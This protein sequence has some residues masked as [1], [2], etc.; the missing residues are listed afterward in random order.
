MLHVGSSAQGLG[1]E[2]I[3]KGFG[4]EDDG[5]QQGTDSILLKLTRFC[6]HETVLKKY[7]QKGSQG[8]L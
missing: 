8:S 4:E 1:H 2:E 7:P 5:R 6:G 3:E